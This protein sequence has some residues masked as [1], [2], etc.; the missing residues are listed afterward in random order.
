MTHAVR[1]LAVGDLIRDNDPR[2]TARPVLAITGFSWNPI[3]GKRAYASEPGNE[4]RSY[5]VAVS[6]IHLDGKPRR[7]GWSRVTV[8][9]GRKPGRSGPG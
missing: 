8:L 3:T 2:M 4:R 7:S 5:R 6:R 9:E 1:P